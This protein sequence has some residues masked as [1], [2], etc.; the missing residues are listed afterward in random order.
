[1]VG[2]LT[3]CAVD[4]SPQPPCHSACGSSPVQRNWATRSCRA[5][6]A[7]ERNMAK[8]AKL[9]DFLPMETE[10]PDEQ[11]PPAM[12]A[13]MEDAA[14]N[15]ALL[16][17]QADLVGP[18]VPADAPMNVVQQPAPSSEAQTQKA[19]GAA[20]DEGGDPNSPASTK[21]TSPNSKSV[22]AKNANAPGIQVPFSL[23]ARMQSAAA[24][25]RAKKAA[26]SAARRGGAGPSTDG[27]S[28][29]APAPASTTFPAWSAPPMAFPPRVAGFH[30]NAVQPSA[31][32]RAP[33]PAASDENP[34]A[35]AQAW[36]TAAGFGSGAA[37]SATS[38][39]SVMNP[40]SSARAPVGVPSTGRTGAGFGS[41]ALGTSV[42]DPWS[43][44]LVPEVGATLP[45][46]DDNA[47]LPAPVRE[48]PPAW[49]PTADQLA[50]WAAA[51]SAG[52]LRSSGQVKGEA[53]AR[54]KPISMG[55]L[56]DGTPLTL[57][58]GVTPP[59]S[60]SGWAPARIPAP[61]RRQAAQTYAPAPGS[62]P[63]GR[64]PSSVP[65]PRY[66]P[67][68]TPPP[69]APAQQQA[70]QPPVRAPAG[71]ASRNW[72]RGGVWARALPA[73]RAA[74]PS[75]GQGTSS[76]SGQAAP[77]Q[78]PATGS[79][80]TPA[81]AP[82]TT[83]DP[84]PVQTPGMSGGPATASS[85]VQTP[86]TN[87]T[88]ASA[89][90]GVTPISP[91]IP[92]TPGSTIAAL[93]GLVSPQTD[94]SPAAFAHL[95]KVAR[96]TSE[97]VEVMLYLGS[98]DVEAVYEVRNETLDMQYAIAV[99][100]ANGICSQRMLHGTS[101]RSVDAIVREGFKVG[102]V[103]VMQKH[104]AANGR[105]IYLTAEPRVAARYSNRECS[106]YIILSETVVT[107]EC[108]KRGEG[109]SGG[110]GGFG[111]P[112]KTEPVAGAATT[113]AREDP[114]KPAYSIVVQ[115]HKALVKPLYVVEFK[116]DAVQRHRQQFAGVMP[117]PAPA[118]ALAPDPPAPTP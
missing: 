32:A 64:A 91:T 22:A 9:S 82:A 14:K 10:A 81:S 97:Y 40:W 33:A 80:Y 88:P 46:S 103:E 104:G 101:V 28:A 48:T 1:M 35:S 49:G 90:G 117:A 114:T 15:F 116:Y 70:A 79:F 37:G 36:W 2:M 26:T 110:V 75:G 94:L 50:A 34:W 42:V 109:K 5:L 58:A 83:G 76:S 100:G 44:A 61:L 65:S 102:G 112:V 41:N 113:G 18:A 21:E 45:A 25:A 17:T 39:P 13:G 69:P 11:S 73:E 72:V 89:T 38:G 93:P 23:T 84:A 96:A 85:G 62:V 27:P 8:K 95:E 16:A 30:S 99:S 86:G 92:P 55:S 67:T 118:P 4:A 57:V 54:W 7:T 78:A 98:F 71:A 59:A 87:G 47:L 108:F 107:P 20:G 3:V 68:P 66:S 43:S 6:S 106:Q 51:M 56:P 31:A 74:A 77:L 52:T 24:A 29:P 115:P 63:E 60:V 12:E 19:G 105:G 111:G 53:N